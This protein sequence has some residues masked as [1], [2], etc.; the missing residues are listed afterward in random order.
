MAMTTMRV[1]CR[2]KQIGRQDVE[3]WSHISK[4]PYSRCALNG[5]IRACRRSTLERGGGP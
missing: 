3:M 1:Q 2:A 4:R 5:L